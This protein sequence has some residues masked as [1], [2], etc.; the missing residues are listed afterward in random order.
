MTGSHQGGSPLPWKP[1]ITGDD[2]GDKPKDGPGGHGG[3]R[4][5]PKGGPGGRDGPKDGPGGRNGPRH[6]VNVDVDVNVD[7]QP[8]KFKP[9]IPK[10]DV[11]DVRV[12]DVHVPHYESRKSQ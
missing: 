2:E 3:P 7:V 10:V 8:G 6:G 4:D 9:H 11:P 1:D 5:G 12:P